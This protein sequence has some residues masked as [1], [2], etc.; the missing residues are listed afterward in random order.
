MDSLPGFLRDWLAVATVVISIGF[1]FARLEGRG[2]RNAE[3]IA[4]ERSDRIKALTDLERRMEKERDEDRATRERD[5]QQMNAR[6]DGI[7]T[8]IKEL[9]Q[10]TAPK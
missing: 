9:L 6:L 10:R 8:D 7:Q 1:W 5:W 2:R 3:D 4:A